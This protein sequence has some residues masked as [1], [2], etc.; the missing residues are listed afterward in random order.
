MKLAIITG[1]ALASVALANNN[2]QT[3][4]ITRS[5]WDPAA[6]NV[7]GR[8]DRTTRLTTTTVWTG[9]PPSNDNNAKSEAN[10]GKTIGSSLGLLG[11]VVVGLILV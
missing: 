1:L 6:T 8:F 5:G 11:L 7:P 4:T 2:E 3:I 9:E 10:R